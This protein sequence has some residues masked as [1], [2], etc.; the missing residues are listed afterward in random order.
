[1]NRPLGSSGGSFGYRLPHSGVIVT[2]EDGS[3]WLVH[4]GKIHIIKVP[5]FQSYLQL[6]F[7]IRTGQDY[8]RGSS[9]CQAVVTY[10]RYMSSAWCEVDRA[11]CRQRHRLGS[12]V[13][14]AGCQ[15]YLFFDNCLDAARRMMSLCRRRPSGGWW[16]GR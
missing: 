11:T 2:L 13:Q 3:T 12:Y 14:K 9:G 8:S 1:M 4:K 10:D 7:V 15:Y 16:S 5:P 6:K